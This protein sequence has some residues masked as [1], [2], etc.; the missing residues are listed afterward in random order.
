MSEESSWSEWTDLK[1][2]KIE[3]MPEEAGVFVIHS[4][5]KILFIGGTTN[6]RKSLLEKHQDPCI[7]DNARFKFMIYPDYNKKSRELIE[8][9]QKRHE[10]KLPKCM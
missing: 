9:Y 5:M 8:D 7:A 4:S 3:S 6:L 1:E 10:G 2:E